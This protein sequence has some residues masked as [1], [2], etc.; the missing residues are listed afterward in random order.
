M[1]YSNKN[2]FKHIGEQEPTYPKE[3]DLWLS[4]LDPTTHRFSMKIYSGGQWIKYASREDLASILTLWSSGASDHGRLGL[5][6]TTHKSTPTQIAEG[7]NP[8]KWEKISLGATHSL[9]INYKNSLM[10]VWG[11]NVYGQLGLGDT[12][13]RSTPTLTS[14]EDFDWKKV[15]AGYY[16]SAAIKKNGTLWTWG[17]N[18]YG[19][20][21]HGDI[22][23]RS[24]PTQVGTD[25]D[26]KKVSCGY[27]YILA[28]KANG[29]LWAWGQN[30][31]GAL[32]Q[33]DTVDR[34]TPTQIGTDTDWVDVFSGGYFGAA[35]KSNGSLYVWGDNSYGQLGLGNTTNKTTP[36][37]LQP[38]S[39]GL[40]WVR[41]SCS[42]QHMTAVCYNREANTMSLWTWGDN[43][44]GQLG[45]GDTNSRSTPTQ[46]GTDTDWIS[47]LATARNTYALKANGSLYVWGDNSYGQLGL[48][49]T[50]S[51]STP[52]QISTESGTRWHLMENCS[53][54]ADL[55][56]IFAKKQTP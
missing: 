35:L 9:A 34:S 46:V 42:K 15:F 41:V 13:H 14:D 12:T 21:G 20:L 22:T 19:Q 52:T 45:L 32:G 51:R 23:N 1:D 10:Y 11:N 44:Y 56:F 55:Y 18:N 26:W 39:S 50:T 25:T 31:S 33:G 3:C 16:F 7:T 54:M 38:P 48:G 40:R 29:T 49:D 43:S 28:L 5:G 36:T 27:T 24:T 6:N 37:I 53:S 2:I 47:V 17:L 4:L 8:Y 30:G